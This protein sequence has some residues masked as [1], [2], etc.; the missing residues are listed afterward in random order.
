[1]IAQLVERREN[2]LL[3]TCTQ[4]RIGQECNRRSLAIEGLSHS[5]DNYGEAIKHLK[6]RYDTP[7]LIHRTYVQ[8][9]V[10]TPS[11]KESN[12]KELR[13]LHD[14]IQQHVRALKT[15]GCELPGTFITSMIE[16]KL[17]T[18]TLFKWQKH[19]QSSTDVP[20]YE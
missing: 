4:R 9:I 20:H 5:G 13:R 19:S 10:D 16:L 12:G 8:K 17:N 1:M 2:S 15:L 18:D 7:R 3:A 6:T 11:I 14:N